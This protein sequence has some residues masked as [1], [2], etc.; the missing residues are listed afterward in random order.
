MSLRR[1]TGGLLPAF[2]TT[3][4]RSAAR[5]LWDGSNHPI[6]PDLTVRKPHFQAVYQGL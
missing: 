4:S 6:V 1:M 2:R 3:F 5:A